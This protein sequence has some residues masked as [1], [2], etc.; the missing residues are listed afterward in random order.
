MSLK[1]W[2]KHRANDLL[3][4]FGQELVTRAA[5]YEWQRDVWTK[6]GWHET[7]LPDEARDYLRPDHPRLI[8]LQERYRGCSKDATTPALWSDSHV[9]AEDIRYFRGDNAWVWQMRDKGANILGY[10]VTYYYLKSMD[11]LVLLDKLTEDESFGNFCFSVDGRQ[12]SRDLLD[13]VAEIDFLNRHLGIGSRKGLRVLDIGAGYGR[14][15]HRMVSALDGIERYYCTDAVAVS[16]FVSEYYLRFRGVQRA[17]VVPLDEIDRTLGENPVELAINVHS[18]PECRLEAIE[19]WIRLL[20]DHRVK[21]L[22]IVNNRHGSRGDRL[23]TN[24]GEEILP[25]LERHGYRRIVSEAKY[26]DPAVQEFGVA[27]SWHNLFELVE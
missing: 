10:A 1:R 8:S 9:R 18:F 12:V 20:N 13:S 7:P 25:I 3:R 2:V 5:V 11:R 22:M 6:A 4:H 16:T 14:L 24:K 19:W 26:L 15:A 27:A 23:L 21:N 17:V